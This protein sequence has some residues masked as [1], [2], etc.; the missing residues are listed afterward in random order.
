M[1]KRKQHPTAGE[2]SVTA[3]TAKNEFGR[4][5][6]QVI[7]GQAVAITRHNVTKAVMLPVEQYEALARAGSAALS[8]LTREFD[9]MLARMQAPA[10]R[11]ASK[12]LF[13]ASPAQL[14]RAAARGARRGG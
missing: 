5:L 6:D 10:A 8:D 13:R 9:D 3:T 2:L 14:G 4:L 12:S 7:G 11:A 1:K